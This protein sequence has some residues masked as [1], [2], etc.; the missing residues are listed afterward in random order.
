MLAPSPALRATSPP[1]GCEV[2]NSVVARVKVP[3]VTRNARG[4]AYVGLTMLHWARAFAAMALLAAIAALSGFAP[5]AA[6]IAAAM[7]W[8]N[9]ALSALSLLTHLFG[10]GRDGLYSGERALTLTAL[11]CGAVWLLASGAGN[12]TPEWASALMAPNG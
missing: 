9:V 10:R 7:F 5:G 3:G 1:R 12:Q 8:L 2:A 11:A 4:G 6:V